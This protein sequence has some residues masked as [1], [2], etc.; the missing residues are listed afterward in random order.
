M[1][2]ISFHC[3][4]RRKGGKWI[5]NKYVLLFIV[6]LNII[7][8]ALVLGE[9]IL[10]LHHVK[11]KYVTQTFDLVIAL[12]VYMYNRCAVSLISVFIVRSFSATATC[13]ISIV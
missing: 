3:R 9:L 12:H 7:D 1:C 8:C 11:S 2:T 4:L 13:E 6:V 10:D 5:L